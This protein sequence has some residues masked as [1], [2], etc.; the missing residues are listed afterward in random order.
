MQIKANAVELPGY[1]LPTEAEWEYACRAGAATRFNYG[2]SESL[3]VQYAWYTK[4]S[5]S[6]CMLPV[7]GLKP[8]D[9]G[10][11]GMHGSAYRGWTVP[12]YRAGDAGLRPA[13]TITP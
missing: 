12:G 13:R 1:R 11:F 5:Q 8:N 6:R 9:L 10:L 4:N 7:G 3:L 2:E